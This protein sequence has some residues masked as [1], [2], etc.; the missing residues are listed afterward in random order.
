MTPLVCC[1]GKIW[2]RSPFPCAICPLVRRPWSRGPAV[3]L[4]AFC[5]ECRFQ[6]FSFCLGNFSFCFSDFYFLL[7]QFL[8]FDWPPAG[9]RDALPYLGAYICPLTSDVSFS[10]CQLLPEQISAF[11]LFSVSAFAW[12]ISAFAC[13]SFNFSRRRLSNLSIQSSTLGSLFS[14]FSVFSGSPT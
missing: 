11:Q 5:F 2:E 6:L 14:V 13:L 9:R 3:L 4:S 1:T 12:A 10:A 8:L 7:S